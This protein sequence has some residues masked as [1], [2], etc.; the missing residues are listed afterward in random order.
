MKGRDQFEKTTYGLRI[1]H[2]LHVQLL[3]SKYLPIPHIFSY[4]PS[5]V[6]GSKCNVSYKK[7]SQPILYSHIEIYRGSIF[8]LNCIRFHLICLYT[9]TIYAE[10]KLKIK[11]FYIHIFYFI[12]NT[13]SIISIINSITT[14][15]SLINTNSKSIINRFIRV[16]ID[17]CWFE[18]PKLNN[19]INVFL[20]NL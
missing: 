1:T 5:H 10:A 19:P 8:S 12:W 14:S 17:N 11:Y 9:Y 20:T 3:P 15:T 18:P 4:L 2:S 7:C 16:Y 13:Y 6:P